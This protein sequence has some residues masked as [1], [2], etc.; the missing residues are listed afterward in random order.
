MI[1]ITMVLA[2]TDMCYYVPHIFWQL[3]TPDDAG[4]DGGYNDP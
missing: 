2:I 1:G 3:R 4:D